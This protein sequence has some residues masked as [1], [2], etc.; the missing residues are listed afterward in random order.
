MMDAYKGL[1]TIWRQFEKVR[2]SGYMYVDEHD[3][4]EYLIKGTLENI[5]LG[6]LEKF[7]RLW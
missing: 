7:F 2:R 1:V 3:K 4:M 6:R 5:G